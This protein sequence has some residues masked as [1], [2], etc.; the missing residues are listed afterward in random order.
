MR[1]AI[2]LAVLPVLA[3][4]DDHALRLFGHGTGDIDRVKI[5]IDGPPTP[6]DVGAGDFTIELWLKALPGENTATGCVAGNDGWITGNIVVDRDV[7]GGGDFG[8]FGISLF[9]SGL[10]VGVAKGAAGVGLC[11]AT[12]IADGAWHHVAV[13]RNATTGTIGLWVDGGLDAT[14]IGPTGDVSYRDGRGTGF[15]NDPFLV[16]GAEKHDAGAAYPS[17]S[18]L[19]DELRLSTTVRYA[20]PFTPPGSAFV[21]DASTAALYHFDDGPAGA[22]TGAVVDAM[23]ASDGACSFGGAAPSGPLYVTDTPAL[24]A[25]GDGT[26]DPGE[27][28]DD[29]DLDSG[30]GC[31]ANCTPTGCGNGVATS[32]EACD[33]G[34]AV[35]GDGCESDCTPTPY[36]LRSGK[37]LQV[38]D[39]AGDPSRRKVTFQSRD[40]AL[41]S[42]AP[43]STGDPRLGGAALGLARGTDEV[44]AWSLPASGWQG[45]G[46][47]AGTQGWRYTDKRRV[48]GPCKSVQLQPGRQ[49]KATCL[50][51]QIAFSLDEPTQG[52]LAVTFAPGTSGVRSCFVFGGTVSRD[53]G[54]TPGPTGQF[55][56]AN[57]PAPAACPVP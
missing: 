9:A 53:V 17:F 19:V 30:D 52:S 45:L 50:G 28:C 25:C 55:R 8:D 56:A 57:A 31:D 11:G 43:G 26:L 42:P 47:P 24:G 27:L 22:C 3:S 29:G 34:N 12:P 6:A 32:G 36:A 7:F 13:T 18:G 2:L 20:A 16:I 5:R 33:D 39:R 14:A 54:T 46:K 41:T 40:P 35:A 10:A 48:H 1:L 44:D 21:P 4:A 23:G 49:L 51:S 37:K 38:S 15:A